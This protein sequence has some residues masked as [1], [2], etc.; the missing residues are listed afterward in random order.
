LNASLPAHS[1]L[2][3]FLKQNQKQLWTAT[4]IDVAEF[5]KKYQSE[6]K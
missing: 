3:H 2:L 6:K 5:I 1:R 4:M